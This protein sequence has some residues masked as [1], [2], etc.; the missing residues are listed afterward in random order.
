MNTRKLVTNCN[1]RYDELQKEDN[2][3]VKEL[4][5]KKT[6]LYRLQ[7]KHRQEKEAILLYR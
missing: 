2:F 7:K 3:A 4:Y 1:I 6:E 5:K